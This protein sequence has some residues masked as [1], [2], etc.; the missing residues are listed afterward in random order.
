MAPPLNNTAND[1]PTSHALA[2]LT[3][4]RPNGDRAQ[5]GDQWVERPIVLA[6]LRHFG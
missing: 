5:L 4:L 3:V 1:N 2:A 6:L